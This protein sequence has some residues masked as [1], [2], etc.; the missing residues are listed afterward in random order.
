VIN[1]VF[2]LFRRT[3]WI[4]TNTDST[5]SDGPNVHNR[6]LRHITHE[7]TNR[8]VLREA[9]GQE[10]SCEV[11]RLFCKHV[12]GN[13]DPAFVT[14]IVENIS[15]RSIRFGAKSINPLG[16]QR[17]DVS[18]TH[19]WSNLLKEDSPLWRAAY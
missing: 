8:S 16:K 5:S 2:T 1:D 15:C 13:A 3:C 12:P 6:P 4:K 17:L 9:K 7:N 11:R 19:L 10:R 14:S 18:I